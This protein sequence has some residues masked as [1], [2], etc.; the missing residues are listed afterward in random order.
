[1]TESSSCTPKT[2]RVG[3]QL[4]EKKLNYPKK[5][6]MKNAALW[7]LLVTTEKPVLTKI[8]LFSTNVLG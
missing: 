6:R 5:W 3:N 2:N 8:H 1:M 4:Y 7:L